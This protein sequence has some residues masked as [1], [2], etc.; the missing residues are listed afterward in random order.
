MGR[1][2]LI[3]VLN[4]YLMANQIMAAFKQQGR[5]HLGYFY[6]RRALRTW[7]A[8]WFVLACYFVFPAVMDGREPPALWRLL[9]FT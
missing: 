7:P 6:A 2:G 4:G 3:F 8:F 5:F 9:T 1:R